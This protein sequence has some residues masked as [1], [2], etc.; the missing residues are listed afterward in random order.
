VYYGGY[1]GLER[2]QAGTEQTAGEQ[3][4]RHGEGGAWSVMGRRGSVEGSLTN[5][6]VGGL[7]EQCPS[8]PP[9]GPP[10]TGQ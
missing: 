6:A 3:S 9:I 10:Q 7:R 8:S 4:H 1:A 5:R 2:K